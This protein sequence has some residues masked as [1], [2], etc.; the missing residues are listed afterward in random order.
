MVFTRE[1]AY[2]KWN[3]EVKDNVPGI[4]TWKITFGDIE[5]SF[6]QGDKPCYVNQKK[7]KTGKHTCGDHPC[8]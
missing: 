5:I 6:Q 1:K 2:P 8:L 7:F 4:P 3:P